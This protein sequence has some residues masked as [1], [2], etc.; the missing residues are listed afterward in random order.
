[1]CPPIYHG[2]QP[3]TASCLLTP[4]TP[5]TDIRDSCTTT[6]LPCLSCCYSP[7]HLQRLRLCCITPSPRLRCCPPGPTPSAFCLSS[8]ADAATV[9]ISKPEAHAARIPCIDCRPPS[10][11]SY[12][13]A[14]PRCARPR[15]H[16][17]SCWKPQRTRGE[18][19]R[20]SQPGR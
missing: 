6:A 12:H 9:P 5:Y 19:A 10:L 17:Q 1:M 13:P 4:S 2:P 8:H 11:T 20:A 15:P 16:P 14:R 3:F 7:L 18:P